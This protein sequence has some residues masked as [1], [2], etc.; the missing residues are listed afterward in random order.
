MAV[1]LLEIYTQHHLQLSSSP[2]IIRQGVPCPSPR[3]ARPATTPAPLALHLLAIGSRHGPDEGLLHVLLHRI[4]LRHRHIGRP[5]PPEHTSKDQQA[6][7][8]LLPDRFTHRAVTE[9]LV[10]DTR[11]GFLQVGRQAGRRS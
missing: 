8:P 7:R 4:R 1:H 11:Q 6:L 10:A 5:Y 3:T 2:R 9:Q